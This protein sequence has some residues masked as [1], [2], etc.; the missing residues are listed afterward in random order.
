MR[1]GVQSWDRILREGEG[2]QREEDIGVLK[3]ERGL[4]SCEWM[5]RSLNLTSR[6]PSASTHLP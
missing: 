1:E 6:T 5:E 2:A 3:L 4:Y